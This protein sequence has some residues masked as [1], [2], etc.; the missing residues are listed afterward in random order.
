MRNRTPLGGRAVEDL[1]SVLPENEQG[2]AAP[3]GN[4]GASQA[5][6][7]PMTTARYLMDFLRGVGAPTIVYEHR[8]PDAER[9]RTDDNAQAERR[10]AEGSGVVSAMAG[11]GR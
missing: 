9:S 6:R 2:L 7:I 1:G 5:A 11:Q 8:G 4:I 3:A 10:P